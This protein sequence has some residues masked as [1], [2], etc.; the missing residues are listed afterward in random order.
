MRGTLI[1]I[2]YVCLIVPLIILNCCQHNGDNG[3]PTPTLTSIFPTSKVSHM[4]AFILT[5]NGTNFNYS[6]TIVFNGNE[7][8]TN[9]V[10]STELTCQI[11]PEDINISTNLSS[12]STSVPN[13]G[14]LSNI[15]N[16]DE[17]V[18]VP[19]SV[20][21]TTPSN[22]Y[23]NNIVFTI[24]RNFTFNT[25]IMLSN[26]SGEPL[27]L[28]PVIDLSDTGDI[29]VAMEHCSNDN[30]C[31]IK[32]IRSTDGGESWGSLIDV[33]NRS[34]TSHS[35]SIA[36]DAEGNI[37]IVFLDNNE[38]WFTHSTDNGSSWSEAVKI[39]TNEG[40]CGAPDVALNGTGG[41]NVVWPYNNEESYI[42]FRRS[43]DNGASWS[44]QVNIFSYYYNTSHASIAVDGAGNI[45]LAWQ[46]PYGRY[47]MIY[48]SRSTDMGANWWSESITIC[49][50]GHSPD[51]AVDSAGS[52]NVVMAGAYMPYMYD[53]E[54]K[55]STD[56]GANW[57]YARI[58]DYE[59]T[60][61]GAW[62]PCIAV[63]T[64]RNINVVHYYT[65]DEGS[66]EDT[67]GIYFNR[68]TDNGLTWTEGIKLYNLCIYTPITDID[69]DNS[70]NIY[71]VWDVGY[72]GGVY[73]VSST[74]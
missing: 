14:G 5:A 10:S 22:A 36:V 18:E 20:H 17:Y 55:R 51:V 35:P 65:G 9:F 29:N 66:I 2:K 25:P 15:G 64:A 4:P 45:N 38:I 31:T 57:D 46:I 74:R 39:S 69:V 61:G 71:V 34:G 13:N 24:Q 1:K 23:S 11:T 40:R 59:K 26:G 49:G 27:G 63:D 43:T 56:G 16:T 30:F 42:C 67:R 48:F 54:F 60:W 37:N 44:E 28:V 70:G 73:F 47:P 68:S 3:K 33:F 21:N 52:I 19:V 41:I 32:F 12:E 62:Y 6:S 50:I 7:M 53:I 72:N 58:T 8:Q